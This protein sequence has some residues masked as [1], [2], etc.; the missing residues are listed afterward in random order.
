M[1][2]V[3]LP[4]IIPPQPVVQRQFGRDLPIVLTVKAPGFLS[5]LDLLGG[6]DGGGVRKPQ[7]ETGV[8]IANRAAAH[9]RR[10][11]VWKSRL[12]FTESQSSLR[13]GQVRVAP[14][15]LF[16]LSAELVGMGAADPR[17]A[18]DAR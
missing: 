14:D 7:Q 8:A 1:Q 10:R 16:E 5:P 12:L 17:R 6:G 3:P 13:R 9:G 4:G 15:L 18:G 11:Q 2:F